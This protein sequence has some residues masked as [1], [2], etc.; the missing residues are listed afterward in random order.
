MEVRD[1]FSELLTLFPSLAP[2]L[3]PGFRAPAMMEEIAAVE[4][5]LAMRFP[6]DLRDLLLC[7]NGQEWTDT[8]RD[9]FFPELFFRKGEL[10][11]TPSYWLASVA[12]IADY[13]EGCR[14]MYREIKDDG[15]FEVIGPTCYHD[16]MLSI[17]NSDSACSL[18]IDLRPEPGGTLGQV[19][20]LS[21]QPFQVVV[22]APSLKSLLAMILEGFRTNR[23]RHTSNAYYNV[24]GDRTGE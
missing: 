21:T 1:L 13:T 4:K 9:P 20:M 8:Y 10:G 23:F 12:E 22:L 18:C 17:T 5:S 19:V 16:Q 3:V 2:P 14:E 24:W 15:P 11:H 6:Q 7:A